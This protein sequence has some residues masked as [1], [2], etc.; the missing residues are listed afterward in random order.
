M[1]TETNKSSETMDEFAKDQWVRDTQWYPVSRFY[2]RPLAKWGAECFTSYVPHPNIISVSGFVLAVLAAATLYLGTLYSNTASLFWIHVLSVCFLMGYWIFD[3]LDGQIARQHGLVSVYG[4]WLDAN[5]DELVDF[6]LHAVA[7]SVV[8]FESKG[9]ASLEILSAF[10]LGKYLFMFGLHSEQENRKSGLN[11]SPNNSRYKAA[12][13]WLHRLYHL[14]AD[15]DIRFHLFMGAVLLDLLWWELAFVA[16]YYN[17]RW[18]IRH[19]LMFF[20]RDRASGSY[21]VEFFKYRQDL[22]APQ[23]STAV[24]EFSKSRLSLSVS[25]KQEALCFESRCQKSGYQTR[26]TWMARV[27][28]RPAALSITRLL[29]PFGISAHT[30]TLLAMLVALA[31]ACAFGLG[32]AVSL[33]WG[34]LLLQVWYLLDHVDG[35]VARYH[36]TDSVS[37][38]Y[39][40]Y[41]MHYVVHT[42]CTFSLGVGL[43][44]ESGN[45]VWLFAGFG[46]MMGAILL[47]IAN[48]CLY[49][50]FFRPL[51]NSH[52]QW[53]LEGA[54]DGGPQPAPPIPPWYMP[55][56]CV[57][58]LLQKSCEIHVSMNL[59]TVIAVIR[60]LFPFWGLV[61][62]KLSVGLMAVIA[63][64]VATV[65]IARR[66]RS[67]QPDRQFS[68]WFLQ[69]P[70]TKSREKEVKKE[71]TVSGTFI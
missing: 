30:I 22:S 14:P 60:V 5:I 68:N 29:I 53:Y 27:I 56:Q 7:A 9:P 26:G 25:D 15:A 59:V 38:T 24:P 19:G 31:A 11:Y 8:L 51:R 58:Y 70:T 20:R 66:V 33:A 16:A 50:A 10:F 47:G 42:T 65:R 43:F 64:V 21:R 32:G 1:K 18:I 62:L 3:Q 55:R 36:K 13:M 12:K 69:V 28:S 23:T 44:L 6:G 49:K 2:L 48:D 61:L 35:Q 39:F 63:P 57:S 40:D 4:G 71:P 46:W 34:A 17:F 54:A 37:G 52:Q 45:L 41:V 67:G